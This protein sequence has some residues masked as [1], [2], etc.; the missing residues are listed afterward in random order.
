MS[1]TLRMPRPPIA[2]TS[3][4]RTSSE[5]PQDAK[6]YLHRLERLAKT[7]IGGRFKGA[8]G[9]WQ[10]QESLLELQREIQESISNAKSR[11]RG[12]KSKY[13]IL[14][15]LRVARW[16]ARR[17]GDAF[18]WI[19]LGLDKKVI[20]S[21]STNASVPISQEGHGSRGLIT[22][23]SHL[24]NEGWGF[25]LLHDVT[26]CL[27]I[28]DVTFI[29]PEDGERKLHTVE[30][31]THLK[32]E[33]QVDEKVTEYE[34]EVTMVSSVPFDFPESHASIPN[35]D[36]GPQDM[37]SLEDIVNR[38]PLPIPDRR[39]GRQARRM[40]KAFARQQA[41]EGTV[42]KIEG[43]SPL[44]TMA[45]DSEAISHWK[46]LRRVI[47]RSRTEGYASECIE[48]AFL[49]A[50]FYNTDGVT[51]E[52]I[53]K[54]AIPQ[55]LLESG[56]LYPDNK[57]KNSIVING[58]PTYESKGAQLFLPYYLYSIPQR[59]IF[60]LMHGRLIIAIIGNPGR[61]VTALED[62]DFEVSRSSEKNGHPHDSLV[63]STSITDRKG[64]LFRADLHGI[65]FF[66]TEA[67]YEAKSIRYIV[68]AARS[69]RDGAE[70]ALKEKGTLTP[71]AND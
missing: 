30:V 9:V 20:R 49:Y 58:I 62:A 22:I 29:K 7:L 61:I 53:Q 11:T 33:R 8:D 19:L 48:G 55:D 45:F 6:P 28:G 35:N 54:T 15:D 44:I 42:T 67:I 10:L 43:E 14:Q 69:M 34:Y 25:P 51:I 47:R 46:P 23:S 70:I 68:E 5:G 39:V 17:L 64:N 59:A 24:A 1:K 12:D 13:K 26:D 41:K 4:S 63:I 21:L 50:A 40:S 71:D 32:G 65:S 37:N 16:H 27:R 60:D 18:A 3:A 57:E 2:K 38:N 31:K 36:P 56:I 52:D 66:I